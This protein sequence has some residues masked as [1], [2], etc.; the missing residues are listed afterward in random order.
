MHFLR[1]FKGCQRDHIRNEVIREELN[2]CSTSAITSNDIQKDGL[3][4][5]YVC[6]YIV[7]HYKL[8]IMHHKEVKMLVK[9]KIE[10][11]MD[12]RTG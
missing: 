6:H 7:C 3:N 10:E 1:A 9:E 5:F 4:I 8:R 12:A 11:E 2:I